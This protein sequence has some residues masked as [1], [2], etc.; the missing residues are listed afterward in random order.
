MKH[1]AVVR[2]ATF[3]RSLEKINNM[4]RHRGSSKVNFWG[5]LESTRPNCHLRSFS[6]YFCLIRTL[7]A[8]KGREFIFFKLERD[9]IL[10]RTTRISEEQGDWLVH[11][12]SKSA[13][14]SSLSTFSSY[15]ATWKGFFQRQ[16]CSSKTM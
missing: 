16:E 3:L 2:I 9:R 7:W 11:P 8:P 14:P 6:T 1:Q 15:T 4:N 13:K 10:V 12:I 5:S